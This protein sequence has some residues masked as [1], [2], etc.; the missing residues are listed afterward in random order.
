MVKMR[1][2]VAVF[3]TSAPVAYLGQFHCVAIGVR[4]AISLGGGREESCRKIAL[5]IICPE[6]RAR[7]L[8]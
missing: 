4:E 8:L 5:K 3:N 6:T 2:N 7:K 1:K